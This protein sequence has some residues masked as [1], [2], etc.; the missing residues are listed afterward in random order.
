[1]EKLHAEGKLGLLGI[2][3]V[4][5]H[6]LRELV[7][8]VEI[9]PAFVQNRC[10]ARTGWDREVRRFCGQHEI[11]YQGFSLLTANREIFGHR[12]FLAIRHRTGRTAAQVIFRFAQHIGML[13]LTGTKDP[14]HMREDLDL[15]FDLDSA[16][17]ERFERMGG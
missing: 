8:R 4:G 1:M 14:A 6:H 2:S 17:I 13:P 7:P 3:N 15:G 10:Y 9:K 5:L 12:D 11:V 16:E